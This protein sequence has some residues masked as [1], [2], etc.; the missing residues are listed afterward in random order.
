MHWNISLPPRSAADDTRTIEYLL[1]AYCRAVDRMDLDLLRSCFWPD[2]EVDFGDMVRGGVDEFVEWIGAN[3][4]AY[5]FTVHT[6]SNI[7]VRLNGNRAA[8]E[9]YVDALHSARNSPPARGAFRAGG[10]Y[11]DSFDRRGGEW[12]I[13]HRTAVFVWSDRTESITGSAAGKSGVPG[14]RRDES[15]PSYA[16]FTELDSVG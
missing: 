2:A 10:R 16:L 13:A 11:L 1:V 12:R 8:S 4:T 14:S 3:L 6:L 5:D 9:S 15:D 7:F